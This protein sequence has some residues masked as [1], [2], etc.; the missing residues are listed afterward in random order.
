MNVQ[1]LG[2]VSNGYA[3]FRLQ[4]SIA[5]ISLLENNTW[6]FNRLLVPSKFRGQ[7][8]GT[9][10]LKSVVKFCHENNLSLLCPI[11]P[12]GD[13][14]YEQLFNFYTRHGFVPL[15]DG[16]ILKGVY[17][18]ESNTELNLNDIEQIT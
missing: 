3:A 10:L 6:M 18:K 16:L 17:S 14:N 8:Y 11:N 1:I 15:E 4:S 9:L 2:T 12:Y 7:G 13:L 5:E